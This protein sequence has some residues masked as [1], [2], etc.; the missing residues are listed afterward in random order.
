MNLRP[1][2]LL[3]VGGFMLGGCSRNNR[4]AQPDAGPSFQP[5]SLVNIVPA[6]APLRLPLPE[7]DTGRLRFSVSAPPSAFFSSPETCWSADWDWRTDAADC[8]QNLALVPE[9]RE[10]GVGWAWN[11]FRG[12]PPEERPAFLDRVLSLLPPW[13]WSEA[14]P[15]L[16]EP[17]WGREVHATLFRRL[18]EAP[19]E[20][21][22]PRLIRMAANPHHPSKPGADALLQSY[23]P[24]IRPG[25]YSAYLA[26]IQNP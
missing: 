14:D 2:G 18:L 11:I 25:D 15:I 8:L 23:F 16:L 17:S 1:V 19:L 20:I 3:V 24:E 6:E 9:D 10:N 12:L 5:S 21:Q 13:G 22:C 4:V 7:P 26:R